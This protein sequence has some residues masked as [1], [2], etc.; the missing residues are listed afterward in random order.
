[1]SFIVCPAPARR[2]ASRLIR[3]SVAIALVFAT[4]ALY[5]P[6]ATAQSV[7]TEHEFEFTHPLVT[8]SPS[9]DTKIR[10][11]YFDGRTTD[12]GV[13]IG[14]Q[15]FRVE[16]EYA[17][18]PWVSVEANLPY[19]RRQTATRTIGSGV[20]NAEVALKLADFAM[21]PHGVLLGGGVEFG[22]PT[23]NDREGLGSDHLMEVAPYV[24]GGYMHGSVEVVAFTTYSFTTRRRPDDPPERELEY[25]VSGMLHFTPVLA[26][27]VE[28]DA[29]TVLAG[30]DPHTTR[31]N[32]SPGVLVHP[33]FADRHILFGVSVGIPV[34]DSRELS[35]RLLFSAFY[36]F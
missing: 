30:E 26:G 18:L 1:M 25:N 8:E 11:D 34:S 33:R 9:P 17:F 23:G 16:A 7:D 10:L 36:H 15:I 6:L 22:L 2:R 4:G 20:G 14:E 28:M 21:E 24:D 19:V 12:A 3:I 32:V 13:H 29:A 35:R 5:V 31:V 27:L